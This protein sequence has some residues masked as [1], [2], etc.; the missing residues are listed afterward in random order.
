MAVTFQKAVFA[1]GTWTDGN[2][3]TKAWTRA[4]LANIVRM[5]DQRQSDAP[6]CLG[7]P[8]T[9]SPAYGWVRKL[10]MI[11]DI[12]WASIESNADNKIVGW[13]QKGYYRDVSISVWDDGTLE[14]IGFLG[15]ARPAV[16][17]LPDAV[18]PEDIDTQYARYG[19]TPVTVAAHSSGKKPIHFLY[20]VKRSFA[21]DQAWL[22][23]LAAWRTATD[24]RLTAIEGRLDK[25]EGGSGAGAD[26]AAAGADKAPETPAGHNAGTDPTILAL[27][28][29]VAESEKKAAL[30]EFSSFLDSPEM[31]RK[32][33]P[34]MRPGLMTGFENMAKTLDFSNGLPAGIASYRDSLKQLPDSVP[35]VSQ[36]YARGGAGENLNEVDALWEQSQKLR[37]M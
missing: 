14:H 29:R 12:L 30:A 9:N 22:D 16:D 24:D 3:R 1:V 33:S 25:I 7:H 19:G 37:K 35:A 26:T 17:G 32:V 11:G 23:E 6:I 31:Q 34:A 4:D 8:V 28:A 21:M 13:I 2:G 36:E 10:Y 15:G 5:Y 27:T 18:L 20:T